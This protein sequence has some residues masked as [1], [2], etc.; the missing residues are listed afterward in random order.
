MAHRGER[1]TEFP[2]Y[3]PLALVTCNFAAIRKASLSGNNIGNMDNHRLESS[4]TNF[5]SRTVVIARLAP[6]TPK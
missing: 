6:S 2:F 4:G 3:F 1:H 5:R